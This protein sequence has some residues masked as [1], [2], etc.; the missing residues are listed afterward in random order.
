MSSNRTV[1]VVDDEESLRAYAAKLIG[2]RGYHVLTAAGGAEALAIMKSGA[3][4]NLVVLD[5]VMPGIDGLETLA[6]IR[7]LGRKDVFVVLLTAQTG[8]AQV[9]G[10]YKKGADYYITKPLQ[11]SELLNII[12]YLIGDLPPEERS[13][14]EA[15]L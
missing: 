6:E 4:V 1:L 5:I 14:L 12:D 11:P 15:A 13:R 10:G 9:L 2:K 8:D 7:N 3:E